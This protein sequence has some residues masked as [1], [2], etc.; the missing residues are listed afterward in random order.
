M[1]PE[2]EPPSG[3]GIG[4]LLVKVFATGSYSQ[5]SGWALVTSPVL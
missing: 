2:A 5:V 3:C 4:A 1:I